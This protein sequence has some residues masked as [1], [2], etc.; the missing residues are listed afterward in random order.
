MWFIGDVHGNFFRYGW[1]LR[2]KEC[3]IQLGD[4]GLGFPKTPMGALPAHDTHKFIR[5]NHDNPAVC[6]AH[7][8]YLGD[9]G[10]IENISLFF[11][12]GGLS[13]DR[14]MRKEKVNYW[15]DEQL[16]VPSLQSMVDLYVEKKPRIVVTHDCPEVVA[17][18][19]QNDKQKLEDVSDTRDYLQAAF[20]QHKPEFWMYGHWHKTQRKTI[21]STEFVC[22]GE[23]DAVELK[24]LSW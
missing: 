23:L 19:M 17:W 1:I 14:R 21:D 6:Q 18:L 8:N 7:P 3:S 2:N 22:V 15:P 11:V 10:F 9:Y 13:V 4:M 20:E 24:G 16:T 5:G 12:S